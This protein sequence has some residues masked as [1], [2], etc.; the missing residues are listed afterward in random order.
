MTQYPNPTRSAPS[1]SLTRSEG[2][3]LAPTLQVEQL[4]SKLS[5]DETGKRQHYRPI[6]SLHKW[7]ARRPGTLFRAIILLATHPDLRDRLLRLNPLGDLDVHAPYFAPHD[8]SQW[9]IFDPFMGGGATLIE[10]NRMGAKVIGCDINPV[11]YWIVRESL[12]AVDLARLG[13]CFEQLAQSAGKTIRAMY[14]TRCASCGADAE[15]LY[16]FWVRVIPCLRC[17][18]MTLL[19]KRCL[20]NEGLSRNRPLSASNPATV[21]C[22]HCLHLFVWSGAQPAKCPACDATFDPYAGA[23]NEGYYRCACS[24]SPLSLLATIRNGARLSER[25]VAIE[26]WCPACRARLYKSPDADD[27]RLLEQIEREFR[28]AEP[29]LILP[30][31]QIPLGTSS[32]RWIQHG[33]RRY[34]D[35][36]NAR[37]LLAFNALIRA[38]QAI[39]DAEYRNCFYTV[40]SNMLEYNN[41]MTPYNYPNRKLHHLFNY[42]ALPLT[43]TPV[44]NNV[45]GVSE[46]GAG[47]FVNCYRRYRNAKA[48]GAAPF[49][50]FKDR[51][52]QVITHAVSGERVGARF[53]AS[54]DA[55]TRTERAAMLF[56][57]D[58][59]HLPELPDQS[60]DLVITDPPYYDNVHYSELSNFFY[61]WL[62]RLSDAPCFQSELVPHER[63]AVVNQGQGK[64]EEAYLRL[65]TDVFRECCRVLKDDG[66][67][68]FTFHHTN[69]RAWWTI[70]TAVQQ[71]GF[72]I[73]DFFPVQSEYKVNPHIRNKQA[74]DMDLVLICRKQ[75]L[76]F[77]PLAHTPAD[78]LQRAQQVVGLY[79][80]GARNLLYLHFV[81]ELLRSA[82]C[83]ETGWEPTAEWFEGALQAFEQVYASTPAPSQESQ[84]EQLTLFEPKSHYSTP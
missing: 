31:Q 34:R 40:L 7:W 44:E 48:Y 57:R 59:A 21:F 8:L 29:N 17:G 16:A 23:Y 33:Y 26:Y 13:A 5:Q 70:L 4:I 80:N 24:E 38:I 35:I 20:L 71:G 52:G 78:A 69:P 81:G 3:R 32:R 9:V 14:R 54:Y 63:E 15:T 1:G 77:Q 84:P 76:P 65:L 22:P 19:H 51:Q 47:T 37:Q 11:A 2:D 36:F 61:A 60:V 55:L 79:E 50:R 58:S 10:A 72:R 25:L 56:C 68:Y 53:V 62:S 43:T 64:G 18:Q 67:M 46:E 45:W 41:M 83:A 39:E 49:E 28:E 73:V 27:L 42:H 30:D 82:S 12:K 66:A 6:Y 75:S 74:L